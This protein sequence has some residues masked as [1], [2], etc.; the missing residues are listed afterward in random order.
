MAVHV[1]AVEYQG[2]HVQVHL[3]TRL[4]EQ[5]SADDSAASP[6]WVALLPDDR[7]HADPLV[8]GQRVAMSWHEADAHLLEA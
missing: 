4:D 2:G 8:P 3:A 7:F 6:G 5:E 1:K